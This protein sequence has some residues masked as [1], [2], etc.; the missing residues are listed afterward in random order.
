MV[1]L[2]SFPLGNKAFKQDCVLL[3][4]GQKCSGCCFKLFYDLSMNHI[5]NLDQPLEYLV[6][7]THIK[8]ETADS[9]TTVLYV[10]EGTGQNGG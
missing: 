9:Y 10:C 3:F 1:S 4:W 8:L 6:C 7:V 5:N 2:K